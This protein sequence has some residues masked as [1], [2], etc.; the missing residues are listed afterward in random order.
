MEEIEGLRARMRR[1]QAPVL[2]REIPTHPALHDVV[3]LRAGTSCSVDGSTLALALLAGPSAAG[4]WCAVIGVPDLGL[5]AASELGIALDRLI[6][7]PDPGG[8]W[9]EATAALIDVTACVVVKPPVRVDERTAERL[10]ARLRTRGAALIAI[11]EWPRAEARLRMTE[12]RWSGIGAG[13]GSLVARQVVVESQRGAAPVRRTALWFPAE[14][15][16]LRVAGPRVP[17]MREVG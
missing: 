7:V 8:S 4:E 17:A 12:P 15:G 5:E 3:R 1:M 13:H 10:S 6:L 9:L 2:G 16:G 14:D 11:G